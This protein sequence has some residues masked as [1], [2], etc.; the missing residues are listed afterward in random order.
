MNGLFLCSPLMALNI[1]LFLWI[2]L[3]V[4]HGSI[5]WNTNLM[6][7]LHS[8]VLKPLLKIISS[9]KSLPS[10]PIMEVN[11]QLSKIFFQ[12]HD[13]SHCTSP[14]HTAEHNGISERKHRHIVETGISLLTHT[15]LPQNFWSFAFFTAIY[16]INRMPS[17]SLK[18]F[19][20]FELIFKKIS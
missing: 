9:I 17:P 20:P 11:L 3:H 5:L 2:I 4:I 16:L 13:I 10:I 19:S 8:Y 6:S 18:Y 15:S 14:P 12:I 1:I 7:S